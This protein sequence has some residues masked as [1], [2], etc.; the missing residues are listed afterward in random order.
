MSLALALWFFYFIQIALPA[1]FVAY[2]ILLTI[3]RLYFHPLAQFPGPK[4]AAAT[5]W[6]E[7]YFEIIK[8][9][10]GQFMFEVDRMHA[11]Y[12]PIVRVTPN[13]LHIN[14][15]E[16]YNK[17]YRSGSAVRDKY[18]PSCGFAGTPLGGK[19]SSSAFTHPF[20]WPHHIDR[21][22]LSLWYHKT[23]HAQSS[24]SSSC[25]ILLKARIS[26]C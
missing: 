10:G 17:L 4:L 8:R 14:D 23:R 1:L 6:Y 24:K 3:Y 20:C 11:Q 7:F 16:F 18:P 12:G 19:C 25:G 5:R 21:T 22:I 2:S 26:H 15:P 13:E 9:P